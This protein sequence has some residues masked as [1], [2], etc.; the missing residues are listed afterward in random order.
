[1]KKAYWSGKRRYAMLIVNKE[2]VPIPPDH[3]DAFDMKGLDIMKSNFPP[4][5]RE[6]GENLI[7]KISSR[8]LPCCHDHT[9]DS[10]QRSFL[11][12]LYRKK[13]T[14]KQDCSGRCGRAP[15]H[16]LG[17]PQCLPRVEFLHAASSAPTSLWL[18]LRL[19]VHTNYYVKIIEFITV[20]LRQ[21]RKIHEIVELES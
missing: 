18:K 10:R 13:A 11:P 14:K 12:T 9:Q 20:Y 17:V 7:K 2:G 6:F 16:N 5:F 3:K 21:R 15:H 1:M 8:R 19:S 4:Y